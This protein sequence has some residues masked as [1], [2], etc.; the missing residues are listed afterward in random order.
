MRRRA[1]IALAAVAVLGLTGQAWPG[2]P[3]DQLR[4][5]SDRVIQIL[6]DQR[7]QPKERRA[8]VRKVANEVFDVNETAKRALGRHWPARTPAERE[9]FVQ[10][11]ADLL[12]NTYITRIDEYG[13]ERIKYV[14][15]QIDGD[16]ALVRARIITKRGSE[17]PVDSRLLRKGDRWLVYDVLI[18]NVSMVGN[19]R[20]QFDRIIRTSSYEDLVKRLKSRGELLDEKEAK[21]R[22]AS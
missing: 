22:R 11:F 6:E 14:A 17:V 3:T 13:G 16:T 18:E 12:E 2:P 5:Y 19:Y 8:A 21:P 20:S 1:I 7:L 15:E 10:L 9:E 4:E